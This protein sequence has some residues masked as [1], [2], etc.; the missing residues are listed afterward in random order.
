MGPAAARNRG[1]KMAKGNVIALLDVDDLWSDNKLKLQLKCL[2][3]NPFVEIVNGQVQLMYLSA[4]TAEKSSY[5]KLNEPH[6]LFNLS[7]AVFKKSIFEKN[8]S[9]DESLRY[10]EDAD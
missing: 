4:H 2:V 6:V 10:S 1:L 5:E 3:E 7:S 8:G 9:F